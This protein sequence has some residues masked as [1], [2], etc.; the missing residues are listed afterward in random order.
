[1]RKARYCA[2]LLVCLLLSFEW[3]PKSDNKKDP[4][5]QGNAAELQDR[6]KV[7]DLRWEILQKDNPPQVESGAFRLSVGAAKN[8]IAENKFSEAEPK[9]TAAEAWLNQ[10]EDKYYL[11]HLQAI[12]EV[13]L[14]ENPA[15]L[16]GEAEKLWKKE[17]DSFLAEDKRSAALYGKAGF[18]EAGVAGEAAIV[19]DLPVAEKI[20]YCH[21]LSEKHK[22]ALDDF[23][24]LEW[25]NRAKELI[26]KRIETLQK[27]ISWCISG[28]VPVCDPAT[29]KLS[30]QD[31][32]RARKII[33]D[34]WG[35]EQQLA[36]TW[37][38]DF[39]EN[40]YL[41]KD[42]GPAIQ[43]WTNE[44]EVFYAQLAANQKA[45]VFK[46][47]ATQQREEHAR[48]KE[49]VDQYNR[50]YCKEADDLSKLGLKLTNS[51]K[52]LENGKLVLRLLLDNQNTGPIVKP[53]VRLC[54]GVV[55]D[56]LDLGYPHFSGKYQASFNITGVAYLIQSEDE[57]GF[58][59]MPFW[60]LVTFEDEQGRQF[61]GKTVIAP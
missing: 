28:T 44:Y 27:Q 15:Q 12:K 61:R 52:K 17:A 36:K 22:A 59:I 31:Y 26:D 35:E 29:L 60:G 13:K 58:K 55:S 1:M 50:L 48:Q 30:E 8:L 37:N 10:N 41:V 53:K 23:G 49:L 42:L 56:E 24:A 4:A 5:K 9:I 6:L 43:S 16:W 2:I 32:H 38:Q 47:F 33:E 51:D 14:K 18:A 11:A 34:S 3:G 20:S 57:Q 7:V 46:D 25:K 21:K 39:P 54:G 45:P 19:S 40:K